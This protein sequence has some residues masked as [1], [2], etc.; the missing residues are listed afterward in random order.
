MSTAR[1]LSAAAPLLIG[2]GP[3]AAEKEVEELDQAGDVASEPHSGADVQRLGRCEAGL[4]RSGHSGPLWGHDARVPPVDCDGGG[5]GHGVGGDGR[6]V[7]QDT[8]ARGS[9]DT[10]G[11]Q[12]IA[13]AVARTG[14]RQR[15]GVHKPWPL[16]PTTISSKRRALSLGVSQAS[17]PRPRNVGVGEVVGVQTGHRDMAIAA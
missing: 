8:G 9:S 2:R 14:Q 1:G 3:G 11:P 15:V 4:C 13:G 10:E 12:A 6:G 16:Q 17:F 7:G 5:R